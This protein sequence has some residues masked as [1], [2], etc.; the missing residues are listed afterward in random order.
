MPVICIYLIK[1]IICSGILMAYYWFVLRDKQ[2]HQYN[3]FYLLFT[4]AGSLLLPLVQTQWFIH[5]RNE[6]A[7]KLMQVIY[8]P[9]KKAPSVA[10]VNEWYMALIVI[11]VVTA[12]MLLI[13]LAGILRL[14]QLKQH[15]PHNRYSQQFLFIET[16]L[17]QAPFTFFNWL[18]WRTDLD[19]GSDSGQQILV[20]EL[21]HIQQKH[22]WDKLFLRIILCFY[23]I[24]PFFWLLQRELYMVH[25]FIADNK[26]IANKDASAFAAMLL[27]ARLG[28]FPYTMA[29]PFFYSP[30]KRR[31]IMFTTSKQPRYS[32][33]RRLM[34][35]PVTGIIV[36]LFA[37]RVKEEQLKQ[38]VKAAQSY[39]SIIA[40]QEDTTRKP[41]P[42]PENKKHG[43]ALKQSITG[44]VI[45]IEVSNTKDSTQKAAAVSKFMG[46]STTV[47]VNNSI[48]LR[49]RG[50]LF[51]N[52]GKE[53]LVFVD[54]VV[55]RW[56]DLETMNPNDISKI[57]VL[58]DAS[59]I[60]KYG[61]QA[62][63]GVI[64]IYTKKAEQ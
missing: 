38:P 9:V 49:G 12:I 51:R 22:T 5:S 41:K 32:Y 35:L 56:E 15:Y 11:T 54:D 13:Q 37:F 47:I 17:P 61:E 55:A 53:P 44:D 59:A 8:V 36:L 33:A 28:R 25:E 2:F 34:I 50:G 46:D 14:R 52:K 19:T 3:R 26:A 60:Q 23:W 16:D 58:K 20:H 6:T 45:M 39:T 10:A 64:L 7:I 18:F 30:I 63:N 21:T 62:V 29:Q 48:Q 42:V 27:N 1:V 24:N 40:A 57:S 4:L 43:Q 31:L